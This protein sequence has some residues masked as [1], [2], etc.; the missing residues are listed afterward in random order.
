MLF[1]Y[2]A[3]Y[4]HDKILV[5]GEI[6]DE[7]LGIP[8]AD[9]KIMLL[10]SDSIEIK[11]V[12]VLK[13]QNRNGRIE[14]AQFYTS[15]DRG[16]KYIIRAAMEGYETAFLNFE[17][18][19]KAPSQMFVGDILLQKKIAKL[20]DDVVVT[21][22]KIKMTWKGDTLVYNADAFNMPKGS[23]LDDLIRQMPGV[24]MN[25]HGEIFVNGRKV[26][27]LLLG[28]KSFFRGKSEV[29]LKNL[30][31]YTVKNVK[32]YDKSSELSES[33]GYDVGSKKFV[34]DV[35]LK[36]EYNSGML[37]NVEVA[38]GTSSRYLGRAFLLG[39]SDP[40]RFSLVANLNNVNESR[41]IGQSNSWRPEKMPISM[42]TTQSV[43]GYMYRRVNIESC[44]NK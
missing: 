24:R 15:V 41:H 35:N 13:I 3:T 37:A 36:Q 5:G 34:M 43:A 30:P 27:E 16:Q 28:S 19:D 26:D 32:V 11:K 25:D 12:D 18:T 21:A 2:F 7:F 1:S 8:L 44:V 29:I 39:F 40:F 23:M 20:L 6:K 31:Y 14:H 22:T 38:A 9:A 4:A 33:L 10:N 17:I 42:L